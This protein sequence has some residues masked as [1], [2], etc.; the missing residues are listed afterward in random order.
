MEDGQ[1]EFKLTVKKDALEPKFL[2][3]FTRTNEIY[4]DTDVTD[5]SKIAESL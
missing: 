1:P 4:L 2:K 3:N 5:D